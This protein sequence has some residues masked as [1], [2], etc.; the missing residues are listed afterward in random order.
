VLAFLVYASF[1]TVCLTELAKGY[2]A[3]DVLLEIGSV[4]L[5]KYIFVSLFGSIFMPVC[6]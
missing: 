3:G 5:N 1:V 2:T 6:V 4:C